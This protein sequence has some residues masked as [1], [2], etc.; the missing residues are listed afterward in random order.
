MPISLIPRFR[1]AAASEDTPTLVT[2]RLVPAGLAPASGSDLLQPILVMQTTENRP[3]AHPISC[4]N[5]MSLLLQRRRQAVSR[6][7][8]SWSQARMRAG[9]VIVDPPIL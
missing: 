1:F 7:W 4:G 5:L 3:G 6:L 8:K 2:D 9:L